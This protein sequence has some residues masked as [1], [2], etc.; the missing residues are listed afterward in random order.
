MLRRDLLKTSAALLGGSALSMPG[1]ARAQ[2]SKVLNFIPYAD[3]AVVDPTFSTAYTTRTHALAVFDTL[4]GTDENLQPHPQMV[5]GHVLEDDGLTWR[6]TLRDG[7]VFHDGSR[8]LARDCVAS[9]RR[10]GA[11][12][13][14]GQVV[15]DAT[16][17]ITA[18]DDKTIVFR[19]KR[20]FPLLPL[21]LGRAS[22]LVPGIMPERL[23]NT[24]PFKQVTEVVGSGP[25]RFVADERVPGARVVYAKHTG[26][27]PRP[28]GTASYTAGPRAAYVDRVVFNVITDPATAA[29]ALQ[30]G[31]ADWVEQPLI[32]LLPMLQRSRDINV[33][34]KDKTGMVGCFRF[35]HLQP[36]FNN[37]A[38]RRVVLQAV[39]QADCMTSVAGA[40]PDYWQGDVGYFPP[41]S[42]M[43]T[44]PGFG[45]ADA[46]QREKLKAA[47]AD[48][49]YKGERVVLLSGA[50]V[51][52]INAVCEVMRDVL[53][54]IGMNVDFV[55]ADWGTVVSRINSREPVEKGG[56]SCYCT[57]WSGM[58][59]WMPPS[60][61]FLR[62]SGARG[63]TGWPDSPE[64]EALRNQWL[65]ADGEAAQ[66]QVAAQL[67]ATAEQV[68]P[69]IPLGLFKQPIAYRKN[70]TGILAGAP[71]FTNL[72]KEA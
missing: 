9:I 60:H 55:A 20:P 26:Y 39:N 21:A 13:A 54:Q 62:A 16:N 66:K 49:G 72:R 44:T 41:G 56:W 65:L 17:E 11:R 71:V 53:V 42:P 6:M 1:I 3:V 31:D 8:V 25:F 69:Y 22:S 29:A 48:A 59:Q 18:P 23:A 14:F 46:A 45:K 5:A 19:L 52:R 35:N 61:T 7:L 12:D 38:I 67:Q 10:W 24:D 36:P 2:G 34:I 70:I 63:A 33:E 4:Y 28:D 51:P 32:D 58:D 68:V 37:P 30:T 43:A 50:D 27:V 40:A 15:M 47:L 64:L 57:Y